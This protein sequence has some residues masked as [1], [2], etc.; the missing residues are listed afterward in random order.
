MKM[1]ICLLGD[2][3][4][5][6]EIA[7]LAQEC[8]LQVCGYVADR[9]H[10]KRADTR[11]WEWFAKREW[12]F[13]AIAVGY[14]EIR[15]YLA[16]KAR[17]ALGGIEPTWVN[18]ISPKAVLSPDLVLQLGK[19]VIIQPHAIVMP[20]VKLCDYSVVNYNCT[21]GHDSQIGEYSVLMPSASI[22][23]TVKIGK[24]V[25]VGT[26]AQI[27]QELSVGDDAVIGASACVI[28][29]VLPHSMMVGIPAHAKIEGRKL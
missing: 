2:S 9:S 5:A 11:D 27:L 26:G 8:G 25:L 16:G 15:S 28:R 22:S 3:G 6:K 13:V 4:F 21:V 12:D 29:D 20:N 18:L 19:G 24:R 7:W 1:R 14:P 23:G 10:A 17:S